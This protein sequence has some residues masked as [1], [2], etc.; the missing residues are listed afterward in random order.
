MEIDGDYANDGYALVRQMVPGPIAQAFLVQMRKAVRGDAID[1]RSTPT[2]WVLKRP[3][4]DIYS[5]HL[6]FMRTFL[7]GL[8]PAMEAVVGTPLLPTYCYFRIYRQGDTCRVHSDRPA[9]EHS[10]SLTIGLSDGKSW[11]LEVGREPIDPGQPAAGDDFGDAPFASLVM[12]PGDAVAYRGVDHRHGR[13]TANPNRWT[14]H[15]FC[16]WVD[17]GGP[18]ADQA[19]DGKQ[20]VRDVDFSFIEERQIA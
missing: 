9:C 3:A 19:F 20:A 13:I 14:A 15:L 1:L 2:I 11:P 8:T 18:F 12:A 10:L 7:W 5:E 6:P 17:P 16:H 4:L